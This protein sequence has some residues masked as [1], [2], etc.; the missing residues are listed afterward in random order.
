MAGNKKGLSLTVVGLIVAIVGVLA[1][2]I[3]DLWSSSAEVTLTTAHTVTIVEKKTDV[4]N[5]VILYD[6]QKI[7]TLSK[8][9]FEFKNT[10]RTAITAS[11][12]I[13]DPKLELKDGKIFEAELDE[14]SPDNIDASV[15]AVGSV[16]TL[17]FK[18]LNPGDYIK[19]SAL[20]DVSDPVFSASSRIKNVK[21][22][23]VVKAEDQVKVSGNIGFWVYVVAVFTMLFIFV[24]IGLLA[25]IPKL[26][27]QL[28]A[29]RN[30][31]TPLHT[32]ESASVVRSYI[33]IDLSMLTKKK[34]E[35]LKKIIPTGVDVLSKEQTEELILQVSTMLSDE[36]PLAG[37]MLC[38]I[39]VGFGGW[40]VFSSVFI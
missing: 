20:T 3:W 2:I 32:G 39:I 40:Y 33:D 28:K 25:E 13:S 36:S 7:N 15:S 21:A 19:F 4:E 18:L 31:D 8:S 29:I 1:P 23:Q 37:A 14:T 22:L 38:L 5:L 12:L 16:I 11:D 34:R 17:N 35:A 10:G 9:S 26:K 27:Q 30:S 6:D 24:F